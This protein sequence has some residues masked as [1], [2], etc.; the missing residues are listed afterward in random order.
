MANYWDKSSNKGIYLIILQEKIFGFFILFW[1]DE[2]IFAIFFEKWLSEQ[3]SDN[4][5]VE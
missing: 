5:I 3:S 2:D 4:P 1:S